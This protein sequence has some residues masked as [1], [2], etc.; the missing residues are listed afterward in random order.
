MMDSGGYIIFFS[1]NGTT[2][3][4]AETINCWL[5][6]HNIGTHVPGAFRGPVRSIAARLQS[7]R[8]ACLLNTR[9]VSCF[10]FFLIGF[11]TH[12]R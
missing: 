12:E 5:V 11:K 3:F 2:T 7:V 1:D 10:F 9:S 4:A 6:M 8:R